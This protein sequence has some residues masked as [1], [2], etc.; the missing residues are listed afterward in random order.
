MWPAGYLANNIRLSIQGV[1]P[2]IPG[3]GGGRVWGR[4]WERGWWRGV[5]VGWGREVLSPMKT[6]LVVFLTTTTVN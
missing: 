4:V 6:I 1:R 5:G 3:G 2:N